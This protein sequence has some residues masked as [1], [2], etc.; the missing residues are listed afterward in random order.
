MQQRGFTL[1]ELMIVVAIIGILASIALP[2]YQNYLARSQFTEVFSYLNAYKN[3]M[4]EYYSE[5]G[6]CAGVNAYIATNTSQGKYIQQVGSANVGNDC[7]LVF[8]FKSTNVAAGLTAKH[9]SFVMI[10]NGYNWRCE[11]QDISQR[12][13]PSSCDGV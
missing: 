12:Y 3:E 10:G 7:A 9:V 1:I 8:Q 13:L 5:G 2:A 11:S 4:H 6:S